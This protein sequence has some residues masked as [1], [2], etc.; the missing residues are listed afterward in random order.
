MCS[1]AARSRPP[2]SARRSRS[3]RA[4]RGQEGTLGEHRNIAATRNL[5][6][7][8]VDSYNSTLGARDALRRDAFATAGVAGVLALTAAALHVF[9]DLTPTPGEAPRSVRSSRVSLSVGPAGLT[10]RF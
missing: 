7:A 3:R 2:S 9:D 4:A 1:R 10:G 6:R 8:E 5:D